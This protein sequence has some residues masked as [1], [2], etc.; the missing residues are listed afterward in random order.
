M[1]LWLKYLIGIGAGLV[2]AILIPPSSMQSRAVLDFIV[3]FVIR[4]G[5][6]TVVPVLF[7]SVAVAGVKL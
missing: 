3:E 4:F 6:Y 1:K 7:F 5:R 2:L